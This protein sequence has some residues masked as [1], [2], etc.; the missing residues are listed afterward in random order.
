MFFRRF[1]VCW[2]AVPQARPA[3]SLAAPCGRPSPGERAPPSADR[4][5]GPEHVEALALLFPGLLTLEL[6]ATGSVSE[7]AHHLWDTR[8]VPV[9]LYLWPVHVGSC[10]LTQATL[11]S[12]PRES[13]LGPRPPCQP[14]LHLDTAVPLPGCPRTLLTL[15]G[16][17]PH[18][19]PWP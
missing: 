5:S 17:G 10:E 13:L 19:Q 14:F 2:D 1:L 3:L 15:L 8:V 11:S 7:H 9:F 4:C 6:R 18:T 16:L 12:S